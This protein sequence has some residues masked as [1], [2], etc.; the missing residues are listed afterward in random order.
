MQIFLKKVD[1]YKLTPHRSHPDK[2]IKTNLHKLEIKKI[3]NSQDSHRI[4]FSTPSRIRELRFSKKITNFDSEFFFVKIWL[5]DI[6]FEWKFDWVK[7]VLN[8]NHF[9][10]KSLWV[11]VSSNVKFDWVKICFVWKSDRVKNILSEK[12]F[13]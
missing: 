13:E 8:E 7:S 3:E 10:W 5:G 4:E 11:K 6:C 2:M 9:E 1:L 12:S